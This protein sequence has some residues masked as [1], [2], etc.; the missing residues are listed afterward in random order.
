MKLGRVRVFLRT[1]LYRGR[2]DDDRGGLT[3][4]VVEIVGTVVEETRTG[5]W[6]D[7]E[8]MYDARGQTEPGDPLPSI[9]LP[10]G[11][12]DYLVVNDD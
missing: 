10:A 2:P 8:A 3:L 12:I 1:P 11:K 6:L 9:V 4:D 5:L 7:V